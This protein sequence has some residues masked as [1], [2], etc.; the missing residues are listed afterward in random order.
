M[1]LQCSFASFRWVLISK[2]RILKYWIPSVVFYLQMVIK[3][4]YTT[5]TPIQANEPPPPKKKK[6]ESAQHKFPSKVS[7]RSQGFVL[8]FFFLSCQIEW[9]I[10]PSKG[11]FNVYSQRY[12]YTVLVLKLPFNLFVCSQLLV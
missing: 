8:I 10:L 9:K 5:S 12:Q 3:M 1:F 2:S 4:S 7:S 11:Y 6:K